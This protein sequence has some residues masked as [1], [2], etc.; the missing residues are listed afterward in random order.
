[1]CTQPEK[2]F[3]PHCGLELSG[4]IHANTLEAWNRFNCEYDSTIDLYPPLSET[5]INTQRLAQLYQ[6]KASLLAHIE[7]LETRNQTLAYQKETL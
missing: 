4:N 6:Q 7:R 5:V 3:C 1:M 2:Q